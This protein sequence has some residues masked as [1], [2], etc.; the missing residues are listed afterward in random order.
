MPAGLISPAVAALRRGSERGAHIGTNT[1]MAPKKRQRASPAASASAGTPEVLTVKAT[2]TSADGLREAL[3]K[4]WRSDTLC[5]VEIKIEGRSF[6]AH[7]VILAAESPYLS[8]L[9]TTTMKE[10]SGPIELKE[11]GATTFASALEFMYLHECKLASQDELQPLLHA[12]SLLRLPL[13][14]A[15]VEIAIAQRLD[16]SSALQALG[17]A[18]HLSLPVLASAATKIVLAHFEEAMAVQGGAVLAT[19]SADKLDELLSADQLVISDE[20]VVFETVKG[21]LKQTS[22]APA[23]A[24]RRLLGHV[25]FPRLAKERQ[26]QLETDELAL[27]HLGLIAKAYREALNGEDTP[28][29]RPRSGS[30]LTFKELKAGMTVQV[31]GDLKKVK[32]ACEAAV[33]LDWNSGM[34]RAVGKTFVVDEPF[35][36]AGEGATLRTDD[37][38]GMTMDFSFPCTTLLHWRPA[39]SG[40]ALTS[41]ELKVGMA[42]Q[43]MGDLEKVKVAC[44]ATLHI[45]WDDEMEKAL[46]RKFVVKE[47]W[48]TEESATLGTEDKF[49]MSC[50]F[51]FACAALQRPA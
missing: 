20:W 22:A 42:V 44:M 29:T 31:M 15:A 5:D 4:M 36:D 45:G 23:E 51:A 12:A 9:V 49:G 1:A 27:Q 24:A 10:R 17:L 14:E 28:R 33:G 30:A 40:L 46:G 39:R 47:I 7:R 13:L 41:N 21:W 18:E 19:L 38:F 37:L 32:A 11:I 43:V 26:L 2:D 8:A 50:D 34:E 6:S 35:D 25:R 3:T 16:P 48:R